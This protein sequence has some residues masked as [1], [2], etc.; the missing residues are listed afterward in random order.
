MTHLQFYCT[1]HQPIFPY[2][3]SGTIKYTDAIPF[4]NAFGMQMQR[5]MQIP[6][7]NCFC[8]IP[9]TQNGHFV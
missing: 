7:R 4:Y 3:S 8:F 5:V 9:E 2:A 1:K 6:D